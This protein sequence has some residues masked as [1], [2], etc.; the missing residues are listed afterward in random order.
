MKI[1]FPKY[2]GQSAFCTEP[3]GFKSGANLRRPQKKWFGLLMRGNTDGEEEEE[4]QL[5]KER[6]MRG[7][8]GM[9]IAD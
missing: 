7:E 8:G 6:W 4:D 5:D 1:C 2:E 9:Q 3:L